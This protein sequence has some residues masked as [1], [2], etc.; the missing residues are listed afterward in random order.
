MLF[1]SVRKNNQKLPLTA[2]ERNWWF[3]GHRTFV[4]LNFDCGCGKYSGIKSVSLFEGDPTNCLS[5]FT[6][7]TL[8]NSMQESQPKNI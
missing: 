1:Y 8:K 3:C 2:S 5:S 7:S 4:L 6:K